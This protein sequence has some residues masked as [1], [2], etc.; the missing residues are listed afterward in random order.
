MAPL[1]SA[2][3]FRDQNDAAP[4]HIRRRAVLVAFAMTHQELE[5]SAQGHA[6]T[7]GLQASALDQALRADFDALYRFTRRMGLTESDA[8]DVLQEVALV[9]AKKRDLVLVTVESARAYL[10]GV[11]YKVATRARERSRRAAPDVELDAVSVPD[12]NGGPEEA[13]QE[14]EA[15]QL[16]DAILATLPEGE[17]AVFV[18]CEIEEQT[19]AEVAAHLAIPPGTVASRLR[20]ARV[21]FADARK[22]LERMVRS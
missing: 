22:R 3:I 21:G 11:T 18:L 5:M 20:R 9:C 1:A 2:R 10:F 17:R 15:R 8:E 16:L 7:L 19:M 6:A 12:P 14:L 4:A 13:L